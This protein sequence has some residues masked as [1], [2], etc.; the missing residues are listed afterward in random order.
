MNQLKAVC[1]HVNEARSK[2]GQR[3]IPHVRSHTV[4]CLC[5]LVSLCQLKSIL[6]VFNTPYIS[7]TECTKEPIWKEYDQNQ[8]HTFITMKE[9]LTALSIIETVLDQNQSGVRKGA[10]YSH[11]TTALD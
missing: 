4:F 5:L 9:V 10:A 2:M 3:D 7:N 6:K 11:P 8:P 1:T